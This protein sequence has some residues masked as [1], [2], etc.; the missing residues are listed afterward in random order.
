MTYFDFLKVLLVM[1]VVLLYLLIGIQ[2][3]RDLYEF[4]NPV[5]KPLFP[6]FWPVILLA[7]LFWAI[8][9]NWIEETVGYYREKKEQ[10]NGS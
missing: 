7:A 2:V 9:G 1:A 10:K 5:Y 8:F 6:L 3:L 4:D